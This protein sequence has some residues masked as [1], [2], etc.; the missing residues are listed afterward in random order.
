MPR[1]SIITPVYNPPI[2]ALQACI[3]SVLGQTFTDWEWCVADDCSTDAEVREVLT[4]LAKKDTRVHIE[5][6]PT[7]GGI[8]DAS[9]SAI[10]SATGEFVVLL[11]HD[12][13]LTPDA[14]AEVNHAIAT[15]PEIDYLYSDEDKIDEQGK[16]FDYFHKPDFSPERLRGQNY[17]SH[18]SVFRKS[19][20]ETVGFFRS[21]F[22]GSQDYDLILRATEKA[23]S[24]F[25]IPKVLYHW[26]VVAGSTAGD[27]AAKPM[28]FTSAQRAVKEHCDRVGINAEVSS[29]D[30]G[31]VKVK[32]IL[33]SFPKVSIIIPTR[34][35]RK[36][37]WGV[38]ICLPANAIRSILE[39]SSYSNFEIILVHDL[40]P[41]LDKDLEPYADDERVKVVWYSKPFDFSEKCNIGALHA[42]G[43][44]VILLNDD[45]EIFSGD[46]IETLISYFEDDD[47]AVVGPLTMLEDGR[48]QSA[49]HCNSPSVHNLAGGES[50][51]ST[52]P[53]GS[54]LVTRE[55]SGV[56]G[57]C[58][59]IP[60]NRYFELG[61]FST[62]FPHSYNDVDFAFKILEMNYR[63]IWTPLARIWHFESLSRNPTVREEEYELLHR[64]WGR[65]FGQ[66]RFSNVSM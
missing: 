6:R 22:E 24:I 53:F 9:N 13:S 46:W 5:F 62:A 51:H 56:T 20:L 19:L 2:W 32:R 63:I 47:V 17:C 33:K 3:D 37:I 16:T 23:R 14:L 50:I 7:N 31:Y 45:T 44:I 28:T 43:E 65:Y 29:S 42:S 54:R 26:R 66:D 30:Y 48:I 52:G 11:D 27:I 36:R 55:M 10:A 34:G 4:K 12:D 21:G 39:R 40:V 15:N 25:H 60:R 57:A 59:A 41:K 35:D 61:G 1:F 64:R 18:L 8:V 49:G 58:M 38:D